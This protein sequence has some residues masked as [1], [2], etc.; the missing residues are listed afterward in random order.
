VTCL[1]RDCSREAGDK[2]GRALHGLCKTHYLR[3]RA[4]EPDWD[5]PIKHLGR[6]G[7]GHV[8]A[9]GYRAIG[10]KLEHRVVM[11]TQIG[12]P[13]ESWEQVHH[14]NGDRQ[15]NRPENLELW[16]VRQPRGQ[17]VADLV[18]WAEEILRR[19]GHHSH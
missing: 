1:A 16:V 11:A 7:T 3:R 6:N 4:H 10:H 9:Y 5:R 15:D 18:E 13:L 19:Y 17:R 2:R 8:S 12:R 14:K